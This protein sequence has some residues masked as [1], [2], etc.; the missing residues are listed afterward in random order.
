L[1]L[2]Q[3]ALVGTAEVEF[4]AIILCLDATEDR[5]E[6]WQFNLPDTMQLVINLLLFEF[7]L[8][9]I[10]QILP[11]ATTADT[12]MLAEGYRAYITVFYN[13]HHFTFGKGVF[14]TANLYIAYIARNAE[15]NEHNHVFPVEQALSLSGHSLYLYAL[16]ER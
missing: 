14:L 7:Q 10:G 5:L 3:I 6:L 12:E 1:L 9:R 16:K 8:F 13:P 15:R 4:V 2:C 11:L